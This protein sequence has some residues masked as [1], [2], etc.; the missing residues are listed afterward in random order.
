MEL[1]T[2][3]QFPSEYTSFNVHRFA[4][5]TRQPHAMEFRW[6]AIRLKRF[7]NLR[8]REMLAIA[9]FIIHYL[10]WQ[11][12]RD[13]WVSCPKRTLPVKIKVRRFRRDTSHNTASGEF[14]RSGSEF[15][16]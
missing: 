15:V 10:G 1:P 6:H 13:F 14:G 8:L 4:G 2:G 7:G 5:A 16:P 3:R 9:S 12:A 11:A